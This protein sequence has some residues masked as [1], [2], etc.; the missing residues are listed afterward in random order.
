MY[1][2][3]CPTKHA[4]FSKA[5]HAEMDS[6]S[7]YCETKKNPVQD[8]CHGKRGPTEQKKA[9]K[10]EQTKSTNGQGKVCI[11]ERANQHFSETQTYTI[12]NPSH[13][14]VI[15]M[16]MMISPLHQ[17]HISLCPPLA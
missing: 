17:D 12:S 5:F 10:L 13:L 3:G 9:T 8:V 1:S 6:S 11:M 14:A 2:G 15:F 4:G 7:M 16:A